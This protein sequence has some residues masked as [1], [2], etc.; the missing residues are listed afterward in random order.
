MPAPQGS[1]PCLP[2]KE[3][4]LYR[5]EIDCPVKFEVRKYFT[6]GRSCFYR[7][8]LEEWSIVLGNSVNS[9]EIFMITIQFFLIYLCNKFYIHKYGLVIFGKAD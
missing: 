7:G 8:M 6:G 3:E 1:L 5:G 9:H 4:R 2:C